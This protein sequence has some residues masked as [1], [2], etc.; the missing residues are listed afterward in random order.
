M[1]IQ[2]NGQ[3]IDLDKVVAGAKEAKPTKPSTIIRTFTAELL[4]LEGLTAN[5]NVKP[6]TDA[7]I[8]LEATGDASAL[9]G[10]DF[11][12]SDRDRTLTVKTK[13]GANG[14]T[15]IGSGFGGI[16]GGSGNTCINIGRNNSVVQICGNNRR[17]IIQTDGMTIISGDSKNQLTLEIMVPKGTA[18]TVDGCCGKTT[19]GAIDGDLSAYVTGDGNITAAK[20]KKLVAKISGSGSVKVDH[21]DGDARLTVSGQGDIRVNHGKIGDLEAKVSGQGGIR[22]N[23]EVQDADLAISGMGDIYVQTVKHRLRQ[24][25]SGMG[26]IKVANQR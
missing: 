8:H 5:V 12:K 25:K 16:F 22:L 1:V 7:D 17:N 24:R 13:P 4:V 10:L 9:E 6:G 2:Y 11:V 21:V 14:V 23:A 15:F 19:L 20:V 26:S 18:I 3:M